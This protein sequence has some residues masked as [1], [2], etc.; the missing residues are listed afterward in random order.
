MHIFWELRQPEQKVVYTVIGK[1]LLPHLLAVDF[2]RGLFMIYTCVTSAIYQLSNAVVRIIISRTV[3]RESR[4]ACG[5]RI[6]R[7]R[8]LASRRPMV[9]VV[10]GG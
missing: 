8:G 1:K 5:T 10:R 4:K 9:E 6:V 2:A 3:F 7:A